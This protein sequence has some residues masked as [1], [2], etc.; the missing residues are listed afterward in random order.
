[1]RAEALNY[2]A[3]VDEKNKDGKKNYW[4][5]IQ[6]VELSVTTAGNHQIILQ[7]REC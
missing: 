1:M 6:L 2:G 5:R 7:Q 4:S 3:R